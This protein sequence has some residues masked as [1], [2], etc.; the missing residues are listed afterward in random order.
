MFQPNPN[1]IPLF[2]QS[3]ASYGVN[4]GNANLPE[5]TFAPSPM[6]QGSGGSGS[7]GGGSSVGGGGANNRSPG[8]KSGAA[9]ATSSSS[10]GST[11]TTAA[12]STALTSPIF[13][14]LYDHHNLNHSQQQPQ[15]QQQQ[16]QHQHQHLRFQHHGLPSSPDPPSYHHNH[17]QKQEQNHQHHPGYA[18]SYDQGSYNVKM[19]APSDLA[20]QEAA[21]RDYQPELKG[22]YV[23]D[24]KSS[25]AITEEYAKANPVYVA[26]TV[27]LPLTYTTYRQIQGDG[28]CGWRAIGFAYF[29]NLVQCGDIDH[30]QTEFARIMSLNEFIQHTGGF[31]LYLFEDMVEPTTT[32][33][34]EVI[35]ALDQGQDAMPIVLDMWNGPASDGMIYH[36]RLLAASWLKGNL[37]QYEAF[38][39][40]DA[41]TYCDQW[42]MPV[43]KEIDQIALDLLFN[44]FLKP[45]DIVLEIAYL[46][47]SPGTEVN[48]H[49]WPDEAKS[50][51]PAEL[52]FMINLLYRPD[53]YDILYREQ[54]LAPQPAAPPAA[55]A[56]VQVNRVSSLSHHH[57]IQSNV[58]S[59]GAFS[60]M[61]MGALSMIPGFGVGGPPPS[62]FPPLGSPPIS[63]MESA[64][65]PPAQTSWIPQYTESPAVAQSPL[66]PTHS[67]PSQPSPQPQTQD[68]TS[69]TSL[70]FSKHMFPVP[71]GAEAS[72]QP[73]DPAFQV[74]TNIF[75][76]S[77][78]NTAHYNNPHFQP[79]EYKPDQDEDAPTGR[80]ANRKKSSS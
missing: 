62:S 28:N 5:Y 74:Q 21:A 51:D 29:E 78:Y 34:E 58:S 80:M 6:G 14:S 13:S 65:S 39:T 7:S 63:P 77:Y 56:S 15:Q 48:T 53:H 49:R 37:P 18:T 59:L 33:F 64:F 40:G 30:L 55:P 45:A 42:I 66:S 23:S 50:K 76:Q 12:A 24:K 22:P 36:L 71:G 35:K 4:V 67:V 68:A 8:L 70:R 57:D 31:D 72:P 26:K 60:T 9:A 32:L 16:Q 10:S 54:V 17:H 79:E 11:N 47:T 27:A 61:N 75:K 73:P 25:Q 44:V 43:N 1:R 69:L 52:G 19:E 41:T 2:Y 20:Q 3:P 46:D 38:I